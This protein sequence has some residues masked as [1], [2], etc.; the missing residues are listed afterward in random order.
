MIVCRFGPDEHVFTVGGVE[1]PETMKFS[2]FL[3]QLTVAVECVEG[4]PG[5]V[6]VVLKSP[7]GENLKAKVIFFYLNC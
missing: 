4:C 2:Q 6:E 5:D 3:G 7:S 1:L